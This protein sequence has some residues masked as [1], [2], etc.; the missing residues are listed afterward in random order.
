MINR[1]HLLAAAGALAMLAAT[2]ALAADAVRLAITDVD[3]L[4]NLQR[5]FGPF[6]DAFEKISGLKVEFFPVSGRTA[7]VEAMAAKQV[8]FVLTGPAEYVVFRART[9]ARPVVNWQRPDYHSHII[10]L[11]GSGITKLEDLKGKKVSFHEIGSTSRHLG[12][13]KLLADAGLKFGT[14]FEAVFVKTNV[15]VEAMQRGDLAA[16]GVN[17]TDLGRFKEKLPDFK[18]V[19]LAKSDQLPDDVLIAAPEVSDEVFAKVRDAFVNGNDELW[20]AVTSTDANRKYIGGKF[21]PDVKDSDYD[22]IRDM[23]RAVGITSF[24][25]FAGG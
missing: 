14:D 19:E 2:P 17:F 6:K 16:L 22:V 10:A 20:A 12:P 21:L 18:F 13:G 11:E 9:N 5:E 7:A 25:T 23:Y 4:E 1:R 3:G 15:G 24:D 8:D